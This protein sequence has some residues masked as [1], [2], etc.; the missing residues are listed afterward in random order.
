[1][2]TSEYTEVLERAERLPRE[3]Q[4]HLVDELAT[5][6]QQPDTEYPGAALLKYAGTIDPERLR[7]MEQA[8]EEDC[9]RTETSG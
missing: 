3:E 6:V 8:I 1:M 7:I 9:E 5:R 4:Q 2:T